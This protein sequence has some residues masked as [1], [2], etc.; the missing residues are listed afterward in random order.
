TYTTAYP[1]DQPGAYM[2]RTGVPVDE[3]VWLEPDDVA[4]GRDTV[5][6]RAIDWI[7]ATTG[8]D[9]GS[10][11]QGDAGPSMG[12]IRALAP[13]PNPFS[14]ATIIPYEVVE[15][16]YVALTIFDAS[17]R[18]VRSAVS[19]TREPGS[20]QFEW[21]GRSDEGRKLASGVYY[22]RFAEAEE[23]VLTD[24]AVGQGEGPRRLLLLR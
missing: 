22:Y 13:R 15:A 1:V 16:S 24:A 3:A 19:Q 10:V 2:H 11:D 4:T 20:Y 21:D 23:D 12:S 6:D 18:Q 14:H 8:I 5:L 17:G 9:D 7:Q